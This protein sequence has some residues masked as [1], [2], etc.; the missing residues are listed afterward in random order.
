MNE[1]ERKEDIIPVENIEEVVEEVDI[2]YK[3]KYPDNPSFISFLKALIDPT[4][5]AYKT[6]KIQWFLFP[7]LPALSF[8][9]F[10]LQLFL[11]NVGADVPAGNFLIF[12]IGALCGYALALFSGMLLFFAF[13]F[14]GQ[15]LPFDVSVA[16]VSGCF[17]G[18]SL[19]EIFSLLI[20]LITPLSTSA[21]LG[22]LGIFSFMVPLSLFTVKNGKG[23]I[24]PTIWLSVI[25]LLNV[26]IL[27]LMLKVGGIV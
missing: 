6:G 1:N 20:N 13:R 25:S 17:V 2:D 18:A 16:V 3:V 14:F 15:K 21:N 8:A 26:I 23:K 27:C 12:P 4:E 5:L 9:L 7:L 22:A 11:E 10:A 24:L 19:I